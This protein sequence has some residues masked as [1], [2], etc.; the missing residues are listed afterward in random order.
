M[1]V[2]LLLNRFASLSV[3]W[4]LVKYRKDKLSFTSLCYFPFNHELDK[5][6]QRYSRVENIEKDRY[7][8][9]HFWKR[10]NLANRNRKYQLAQSKCQLRSRIIDWT[11]VGTSNQLDKRMRVKH[12]YDSE[13][14]TYFAKGRMSCLC[15][16]QRFIFQVENRPLTNNSS[17]HMSK[18]RSFSNVLIVCKGQTLF[19]TAF[20]VGRDQMRQ[21]SDDK[22]MQFWFLLWGTD[23]LQGE[24]AV[25]QW[26]LRRMDIIPVQWNHVLS[27]GHLSNDEVRCWISLQVRRENWLQADKFQ[28]SSAALSNIYW[29]VVKRNVWH[30]LQCWKYRVN[31]VANG[32]TTWQP[33]E[34]MPYWDR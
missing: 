2:E 24:Q 14:K 33:L 8:Q 13:I 15:Q 3:C 16:W 19:E 17:E 26:L 30:H 22:F 34:D 29:K 12:M 20:T 4:I 11:Y 9:L 32:P 7:H 31:E 23:V 5:V 1:Y 27:P 18:N 21:A 28:G 6:Q 10:T 25:K